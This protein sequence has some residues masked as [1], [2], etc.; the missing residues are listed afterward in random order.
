[1]IIGPKRRERLFQKAINLGLDGAIF[2]NEMELTVS[3]LRD[4]WGNSHNKAEAVVA[5][6]NT[7]EAELTALVMELGDKN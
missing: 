4:E 3:M 6:H 1:M 2:Q 5:E 7:Y